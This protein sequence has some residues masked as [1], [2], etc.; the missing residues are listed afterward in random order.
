[1]VNEQH[2]LK[3]SYDKNNEIQDLKNQKENLEN[4]KYDYKNKIEEQLKEILMLRNEL[5]GN[6]NKI[7][8]L[9]AQIECNTKLKETLRDMIENDCTNE[10]LKHKLINKI[11]TCEIYS[12]LELDK[13]YQ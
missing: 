9:E 2:L 10:A 3:M 7:V 13:S 12:E 1:M 4:Q 6:N 8:K 11:E 5:Q